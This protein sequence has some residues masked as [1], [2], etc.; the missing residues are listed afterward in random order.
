MPVVNISD[1]F[2]SSK[3]YIT[4][5]DD[6]YFCPGASYSV[7]NPVCNTK[8]Y[9]ARNSYLMNEETCTP[10]YVK[11]GSIRPSYKSYAPQ[12]ENDF[13]LEP[14]SGNLSERDRVCSTDD[15]AGVVMDLTKIVSNEIQMQQKAKNIVDRKIVSDRATLDTAQPSSNG[16]YRKGKRHKE[17]RQRMR[18]GQ[19]ASC[20]ATTRN[21]ETNSDRQKVYTG[22]IYAVA[23]KNRFHEY[24]DQGSAEESDV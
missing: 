22:D 23:Y 14:V 10:K 5:P 12:D 15:E 3:D 11:T 7:I 21:D 8:S 19:R 17:T 13:R 6:G 18:S 20:E 2:G 4:D 24:L 1:E 16:H 9:T